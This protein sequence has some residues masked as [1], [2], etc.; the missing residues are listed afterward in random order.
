VQFQ[1]TPILS[2]TEGIEISLG[3]GGSMRP[4]KLKKFVKFYWNWGWGGVKKNPFHRGGMGI[5]WNHTPVCDILLRK[6][7]N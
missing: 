5:F 2:P 1:K 6:S 7:T 3:E 4:K